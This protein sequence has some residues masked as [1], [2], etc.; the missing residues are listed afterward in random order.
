MSTIIAK[1]PRSIS[2]QPLTKHRRIK[3]K[4]AQTRK[5]QGTEAHLHAAGNV[6]AV[7]VEST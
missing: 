6:V 1:S 3:H 2:A 7:H 4:H 5:H